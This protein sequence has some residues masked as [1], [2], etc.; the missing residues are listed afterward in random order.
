[1]HDHLAAFNIFLGCTQKRE[2]WSWLQKNIKKVGILPKTFNADLMIFNKQ[3]T[4]TVIKYF[5]M[6]KESQLMSKE[7]AKEA[8]MF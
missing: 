2:D 8:K 7:E 3:P 1:M 5:K 4:M 6:F